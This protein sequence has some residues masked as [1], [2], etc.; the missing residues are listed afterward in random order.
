[1]NDSARV[2]VDHRIMGGAPCVCGTRI[3]VITVLGLLGEGLTSAEVLG[4][5]PQLVLDDVLACLQFAAAA[6]DQR[7][8]PLRL[9]EEPA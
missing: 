7:I 8:L 6:L 1:M 4:Q 9:P 3:P 5:Y 2:V